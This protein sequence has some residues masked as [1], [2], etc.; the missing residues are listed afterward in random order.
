MFVGEVNVLIACML[1]N[2]GHGFV[3]GISS[4]QTGKRIDLSM[5]RKCL[6]WEGRP[7]YIDILRGYVAAT[8]W[9]VV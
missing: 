8:H 3:T 6:W 2:L 5:E 1:A 7:P 9:Y 4:M